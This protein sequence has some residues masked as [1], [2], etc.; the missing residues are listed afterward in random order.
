[1]TEPAPAS[2]FKADMPQIPGVSGPSGR[3]P[4]RQNPLMP[5]I[6]AF[7]VLGLVILLAARWFSR[8]KPAESVRAEPTPQME[9][10]APPP[11]PNALLPH[12]SEFNPV[13]ASLA[14]LAKPWSSVDFLL[15]N[16]LNGEEIPA[17]IVR[18]PEGSPG[19]A[20]GYWAFSRKPIYG[21]C[22]LEYITDLTRLRDEYEFRS[23]RHPLVG[24]PCTHVLYDPLRTAN[25][26]GNTW[27]RGAIVQGSDIRPPYGIEIKVQGKEILATRAE[28]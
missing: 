8:S 2:R 16:K 1:M 14:D 21:S 11:D 6:V 23:P 3:P 28:Q 4:R 10:P 25:L 9:V 19:L 13:V 15:R 17:T 27:I 22:K 26:P 24:N 18:L 12:V 5:L 20:S 7:L